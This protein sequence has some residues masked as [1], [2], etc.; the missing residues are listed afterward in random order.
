MINLLL[1]HFRFRVEPTAP[2]QLPAYNKGNVIRGGFGSTFRLSACDAQAGLSAGA[3]AGRIVCHEGCQ[4]RVRDRASGRNDRGAKRGY[5]GF[6]P[7]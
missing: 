1:Q 5:S 3:Q 2:L 7:L 4:D 6:R